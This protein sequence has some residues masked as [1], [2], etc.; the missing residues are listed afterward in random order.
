MDADP[1]WYPGKAVLHARGPKSVITARNQNVV[2]QSAM[3]MKA[4]GEEPTYPALVPTNLVALLNPE[5]GKPVS[6]K[7]VYA[8]LTERCY[9]D[10]GNPQDLWSHHVRFSKNALTEDNMA[11]R[12]RWGE[13]EQATGQ[14]DFGF[15]APHLFGF[16]ERMIQV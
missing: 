7:R 12:R 15:R 10:P 9:D 5:T 1:D 6:K 4:R 11:K 8:I 3:S 16:P 14:T 2:A 13:Q